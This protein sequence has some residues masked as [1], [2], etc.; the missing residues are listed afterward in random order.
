MASR[1]GEQRKQTQRPQCLQWCLRARFGPRRGSNAS[2]HCWHALTI[3]SGTHDGG[4]EIVESS[5]SGSDLAAWP[6]GW[7]ESS[8]AKPSRLGSATLAP[9]LARSSASSM[10]PPNAAMCSAVLPLSA[11]CTSIAGEYSASISTRRQKGDSRDSPL[12]LAS[13]DTCG[14]CARASNRVG[15]V[16]VCKPVQTRGGVLSYPLAHIPYAGEGHLETGASPRIPRPRVRSNTLSTTLLAA[17]V[18][19]QHAG[20]APRTQR[21]VRATQPFVFGLTCIPSSPMP[22][23]C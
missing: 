7:N 4:F 23:C 8:G 2:L 17:S 16:E 20:A 6:L 12:L 1:W 14:R 15:R 19:G 21:S 18:C 3:L 11:S 10:Q 22:C 9:M 5:S 13:E